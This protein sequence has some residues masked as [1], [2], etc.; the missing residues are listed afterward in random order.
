[1]TQPNPKEQSRDFTVQE[2]S[3][4][5]KVTNPTIYRMIN[6]GRLK[7]YLIGRS[8]RITFESVNALR[9]ARS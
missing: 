4:L 8:R 5:F 7:A 6:E 3:A 9:E 2:A 1:M